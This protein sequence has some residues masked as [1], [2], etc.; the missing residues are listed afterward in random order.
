MTQYNNATTPPTPQLSEYVTIKVR[1]NLLLEFQQGLADL[2][3]W[4]RG[5]QAASRDSNSEYD[6]IGVDD[7][8]RLNIRLKEWIDSP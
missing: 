2:M 5:Y 3:C 8:Q 4:C 6:P 7:C 1:R